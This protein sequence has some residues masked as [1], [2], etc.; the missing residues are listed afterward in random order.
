MHHVGANNVIV[1]WANWKDVESKVPEVR[2]QMQFVFAQ[3][4]RKVLDVAFEGHHWYALM[5]VVKRFARAGSGGAPS[6]VTNGH[7]NRTSSCICRY[8]RVDH[9]TYSRDRSDDT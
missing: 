7:A 6:E 9:T 8:S 3:M 5:P 1:P 4:V 2:A